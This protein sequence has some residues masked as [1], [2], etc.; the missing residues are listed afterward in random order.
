M[1]LSVTELRKAVEA[2]EIGFSPS[3]EEDQWGE[4]SINLRLS[5]EFTK[6]REF[7][8]ALSLSLASG[9]GAVGAMNIWDMMVLEKADKHGNV[10]RYLLG[11]GKFILAQT[12][13]LS[14]SLSRDFPNITAT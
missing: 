1:I 9:L 12:S 5:F 10:P 11:P 3:L 13:L 8:N 7:D 6:L 14:G 4:A 2:N